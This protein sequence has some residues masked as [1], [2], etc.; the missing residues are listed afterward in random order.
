MCVYIYIY[1]HTHIYPDR[2]VNN[3]SLATTGGEDIYIILYI[4][5]YM[6]TYI[7]IHIMGRARDT[8]L[9]GRAL[10]QASGQSSGRPAGPGGLHPVSITRLPLRRFSPGAGL[11]SSLFFI[12]RG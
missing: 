6:Y 12:G 1:I 4:Y 9:S 8:N 5:I 3:S 7:Y 11:L 10:S 2:C